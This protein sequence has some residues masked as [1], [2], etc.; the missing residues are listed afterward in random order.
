MSN[1]LLDMYRSHLSALPNPLS[2]STSLLWLT[3]P[4][5]TN[6]TIVSVHP[7]QPGCCSVHSC[8][9][10]QIHSM[11]MQEMTPAKWVWRWQCVQLLVS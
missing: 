4:I 10:M 11:S 3:V 9:I 2:F 7:V 6:N 8:S 1:S 5:A